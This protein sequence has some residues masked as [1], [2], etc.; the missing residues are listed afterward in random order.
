MQDLTTG[1]YTPLRSVVALF[2][3]EHDKSM[4]DEDKCWIL[5]LRALTLLNQ[6]IAAEPLTVR[7]A[8]MASKTVNFPPDLIGWSKIG[9]MNQNAELC[10]LRVNRALTSLRSTSP[11]RLNYLNGDVSDGLPLLAGVPFFF[12]YF[13]N[14][15]FNNLYGVG[16]GL[17]TYGDCR[18]DERNNVIIFDQNFQYSEILLEYISSPKKNDDYQVPTCLNEAVIAFIEWKMKLNTEENFYARAVEGRR[19]LPNKKVTW[20]TLNDTIRQAN[21]MKLRS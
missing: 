11:N 20:Q 10:V 17:V 1:L 9:V 19:A 8:L 2:L 3:D 7:L 5:G 15:A 13:N 4:G 14:G 6:Q 12:N 21:G 16:G 18:V